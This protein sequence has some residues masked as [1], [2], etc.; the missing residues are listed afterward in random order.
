MTRIVR[1]EL[2]TVIL[3]SNIRFV[4]RIVSVT[5]AIDKPKDRES[6]SRTVI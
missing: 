3:T 5:K 2:S 1:T 6:L 4:A